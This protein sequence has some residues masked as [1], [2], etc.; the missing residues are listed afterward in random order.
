M[1]AVICALWVSEDFHDRTN[2]YDEDTHGEDST[3]DD[4]LFQGEPKRDEHGNWNEQHHKITG[5]VERGLDVGIMLQRRTL[6][7]GRWDGPVTRDG[8]AGCEEGDFGGG[9]SDQNVDG[10]IFDPLLECG[11]VGKAGIHD[12]KTGFEGVDDIQHGLADYVSTI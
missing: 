6:R 3:Q 7:I 11:S 12:Q 8:C 5:E 1:D 9:P 10:K 4:L 2:T